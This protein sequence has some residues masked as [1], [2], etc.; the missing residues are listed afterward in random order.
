MSISLPSL[1][2]TYTKR[3]ASVAISGATKRSFCRRETIVAGNFS[4]SVVA[5]IKTTCDGGSSRVFRKAFASSLLLAALLKS[6]SIM[7]AA[8]LI[9]LIQQIHNALV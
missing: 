7:A 6:R 1:C 4:G 8:L 5:R 3:F 2:A 9:Q